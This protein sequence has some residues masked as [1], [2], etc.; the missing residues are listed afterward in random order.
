VVDRIGTTIQDVRVVG[1]IRIDEYDQYRI[2]DI[3]LQK[4]I[5]KC[6]MSLETLRVDVYIYS[7]LRS[8]VSEPTNQHQQRNVRL[9]RA[10]FREARALIGCVGW[11]RTHF[12]G[13]MN[14]LRLG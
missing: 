7:K 11:L 1:N 14:E 5:R 2:V 9:R 8:L 6:L 12:G 3:Q 13:L 10:G 4:C